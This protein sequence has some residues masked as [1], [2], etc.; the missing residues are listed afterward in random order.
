MKTDSS[1]KV[2]T[3]G[4]AVALFIGLILVLRSFP[5]DSRAAKGY[6]Y[7]YSDDRVLSPSETPVISVRGMGSTRI[8]FTV[9]KFDPAVHYEK[10]GSLS[11]CTE[12]L[13]QD[14]TLV[15][16]FSKYPRAK[17]AGG[18]FSINL[19]VRSEGK[20]GY[21]IKACD[22]EGRE[23]SE[24][25][26]V[27]D[28]G[29]LTKM[30]QSELFVYAHT[31]SEDAPCENAG[32][33]VYG[34]NRKVIGEGITDHDGV[35]T[36]NV[37]GASKGGI[38]VVGTR[39]DASGA[40]FAQVSSWRYWEDS[41]YKVY[42]YTD[43]P[44]YRPG[45]KVSFK[46]ILREDVGGTFEVLDEEEVTIEVRD[47]KDAC[48]Y[49]TETKTNDY[50]SFTGEVILG[51]EPSLGTYRVLA[52]VRG[53]VHYGWF[54]VAEY[55]K[56][57]Y[58]I[59]VSTDKK[60]YVAGD[61]ISA[62]IEATYYFGKPVP[63][64]KVRYAVYSQPYYRPYY[65]TEDLGYF[66]VTDE[67]YGYYG[68][69]IDSGEGTTSESGAMEFAI[70]T[71]K[72]PRSKR[73]FIEATVTD[74]S[75]REVTGRTSVILARG[76][77]DL[78]AQPAEYVVSPGAPVKVHV[79][80]ETLEGKP[81]ATDLKWQSM[82]VKWDEKKS[83]RWK[84]ESGSFAT[85]ADGKADFEFTPR[86]E[87]SYVVEISG[88][89]SRGNH[90]VEEVYVW[91]AGDAGRWPS[92]GGTEIEII[93]DKDVYEIG[94]TAKVLVN[95]TFDHVWAVVAIEGRDLTSYE[96]VE[97]TGHT[98]LFEVAITEELSPNAFFTVTLIRGKRLYSQEKVMYVSVKDKFLD[99]SIIP[100]KDTYGPG[101][102]AS[103]TIKT[104]DHEGRPV[105][106]EVSVGI[107]DA[108]IYAIQTEL[109]PD[110]RKAFYGS[111]WNRTIT[112]Y[113]FP[114]WYYGGADKEAG[115]SDVRK[116]FPDTAFW[117][118]TIVTDRKGTARV[119]F[120]MPD[121]LT[122]WRAT[123][124]AHTPE[125]LVGFATRDVITTKDLIVRLSTPRFF[126]LDDTTYVST[127]VHNYTD[128][129]VDAKV[130]LKADGVTLDDG[131]ER[132]VTL[133][134]GGQVL[135]DWKVTCD[136]VG[137]AKFTASAKAGR[138]QDA[139]EISVPVLPFGK[140]AQVFQ[141]GEVG[142]D[143]SHNGKAQI[144]FNIPQN[145][146]DDTVS[147][148]VRLAPSVAATA[149]GA[150][151]Y[152]TSYPYGC[153]EQTMNSFLPNIIVSKTLS[154]LGIK[155]P[156][157]SKDLPKMVEAGLARIYRYQ[158]DEGGWGWWEYDKPNA[159]MTAYAVYGLNLAKKAGF[160]VDD[161]VLM[162]GKKA[163]GGFLNKPRNVDDLTYNLFVMSEVGENVLPRLDEMITRRNELSN[164]SLA[165]L[166]LT[167]ENVERPDDAEIVLGDLVDRSR[168]DDTRTYWDASSNEWYWA[169]NRVETT[170]YGLLAMLAVD[171]HNSPAPQVVRW[172]SEARL[173]NAWNSTK[174]TA[175]AIMALTEYMNLRDEIS[176]SLTA[177]AVLNGK[178][179]EK[180]RFTGKNVWDKETKIEI[181]PKQLVAGKNEL[182]IEKAGKGRLYYSVACEYYTPSQTLA[183]EENGLSV[184]R[185]YY[186]KVEG[187]DTYEPITGPVTPG[188][189]IT[190]RIT[191]NTDSPRTYIMVED[192]L[193]SGFE[194]V[195]TPYDIYSWDF[196][197]GRKEVRDEKVAIFSAYLKEGE[198]EIVYSIRAERPGEYKVM[199]TRVWGMYAPDVYGT[200]ESSEIVCELPNIASFSTTVKDPEQNRN[201]NIALAASMI[202][203][204]VIQPGEIFS[205]DKVLGPRLSSTGYKDA[206]VI[207]GG[208][209]MPGVAG[210][211]C[212][213]STTLYNAAL[214]AGLE[215]I[216]RHP[217]SQP[218]DYVPPGLDATVSEDA[219][220]DLRIKNQ[221]DVPV[222]IGARMEGARLIVD[223]RADL[224]MPQNIHVATEV[225]DVE[226]PRLLGSGSNNARVSSGKNGV[227]VAV[228]RSIDIDG[229]VHR[230]LIS[231][232]YYK[233]IHALA[234][235]T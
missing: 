180:T 74:E 105:R 114:R 89:D 81:F 192:P 21:L 174:D 211:I 221:L 115:D 217:H 110:I 17:K 101:E 56:P 50:G 107:V 60:T 151:E 142:D 20:G 148:E 178:R 199:P 62:K 144:E 40:S 66:S 33:V 102:K 172:L 51:D 207:S 124:R 3:T 203:G 189:E 202:D 176:P 90:I 127:I 134:P 145:A 167:L 139:L 215:I 129:Q 147:V 164:Y 6:L 191:I 113:S 2:L 214:R 23:S 26:L 227:R 190:V 185:G 186:R 125:T 166:A 194:A 200:S 118:P 182:T 169:D 233:P 181:D 193:P 92:Y 232:D 230:E 108:S 10:H 111:I 65:S 76:L 119:S 140:Q 57:E 78:V 188:D 18:E 150:L 195:D 15:R 183:P 9:W 223:V 161:G 97:L 209:S 234:Y 225:L 44:I 222:T 19:N 80:A 14:A 133:E 93:T 155:M 28:L 219:G 53:S 156:E 137:V 4:V 87:G 86:E 165:L 235:D 153:V 42:I 49:K 24:W 95:T 162:R 208:K 173:G 130:N 126:T 163:L 152:L 128:R 98:R 224:L 1:R 52:N 82:K 32:I 46:G 171:P 70:K 228:W 73:L 179:V 7:M 154:E 159:R 157:I 175:I 22:S 64:A 149:L 123:V 55:R 121:S 196:W 136:K 61:D 77:F 43:R 206:R 12:I 79:K 177:T 16:K 41:R 146:L 36:L 198:N 160:Q 120:P 212:Q 143:P 96:V 122:T 38:S 58:E 116:D 54:K 138:A 112:N 29:L 201:H 210:G 231:E 11:S 68:E 71:E 34:E 5:V 45:Q 100:D 94:D 31:F 37:E 168:G 205:F 72:I 91:V 104:C 84:E 27:T 135:L 85:Q 132:K 184:R 220:L 35:Y 67:Y 83:T 13:P 48:I 197:Y 106:A 226:R 117:E 103:Y 39:E 8:D 25:F 63:K 213:V 229:T 75:L 131:N 88:S 187:T 158:H 69:L 141:G 109:A 59:Q 47:A 216:E 30:G 204:F 99:V 218:V 170:A